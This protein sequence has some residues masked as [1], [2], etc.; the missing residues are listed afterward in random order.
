MADNK[1]V[2]EDM[3]AGQGLGFVPS[4][5][6]AT[7]VQNSV[8]NTIKKGAEKVVDYVFDKAFHSNE[9]AATTPASTSSNPPSRVEFNRRKPLEQLGMI[10]SAAKPL[11][12]SKPLGFM[13]AEGMVPGTI[14]A[15]GTYK[16]YQH[17]KQNPGNKQ[18]IDFEEVFN[19][20]LH[21][22]ANVEGTPQQKQDMRTL[23]DNEQ[24]LRY[25]YGVSK[26]PFSILNGTD[27][28][29][30]Q[31]YSIGNRLLDPNDQLFGEHITDDQRKQL[32]WALP[33]MHGIYA[34]K[35]LYRA[36]VNS[37]KQRWNTNNPSGG[38]TSVQQW[39]PPNTYTAGIYYPPAS[40]QPAANTTVYPAN[41]NPTQYSY[42]G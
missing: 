36:I 29:H 25:L 31:L 1:T 17:N 32:S 3:I 41:T 38:R 9:S 42:R 14:K 7:A 40:H 18:D 8:K 4:R 5:Q 10:V 6:E 24:A 12:T 11:V 15:Y 23:R 30:R 35:L 37:V 20:A 21:F 39:R 26:D 13:I 34:L 33:L 22:W 16:K 19:P 28:A 2:V 27:D